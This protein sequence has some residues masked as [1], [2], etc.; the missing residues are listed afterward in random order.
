MLLILSLLLPGVHVQAQD[1]PA[2]TP[3][4]TG[5]FR[6][7]TCPFVLPAPERE[8][9]SYECGYVSV[10]M[11]YERNEGEIDLAV[12]IL[13]ATGS[14]VESDPILWLEGGP[15][16][17]ALV[18][19]DTNRK[20]VAQARE[21][22]DVILYDQRGAG[23]SG[24]LEC[25]S[26]QSQA[27]QSLAA[28]GTP[29]PSPLGSD[30]TIDEIYDYALNSA[31][32]GYPECWNG[33]ANAGIDP[34][35]FNTE[36][37]ARDSVEV[38]TALGYDQATLWGTSYGGRVAMAIMRDYPKWVR[39]AVLDSPLPIGIRRLEQF[40][41]LETEP[42][43]H[44]FA[45]C[46]ADAAC[47]R[48]YPDLEA[49]TLDLIDALK[50]SPIAVSSD[51]GAQAGLRG[52]FD[53]NA[54]VRL[55]T[56]SLPN[57]PLIAGAI[58]RAISDLENGDATV[59]LALLSGTYPPPVE[60][61][62][63]PSLTDTSFDTL[64]TPT[65]ARLALSLAMRTFVLCNDEAGAVTLD[66]IADSEAN[67]PLSMLRTQT[68]YR[69]AVTLFAQCRALDIEH[70]PLATDPP[71]APIPTLVLSGDYDA[72]TAPSW[73][74]AAADA[75]PS[76][77]L[78]SVPSAGHATARW[79]TCARDIASAFVDNPTAQLDTGC[80]SGEEPALLGPN[81]PLA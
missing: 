80:L 52:G 70:E 46:A 43:A 73:A 75:L 17:S 48:A 66:D 11:S 74:K 39:A 72:T 1:K 18:V 37:I 65:D 51:Q 19:A 10:P 45:W 33:Y 29:Y 44:L 6:S 81:D 49:R 50:R 35:Q 42:A 3:I 53:G 56:S 78:V 9:L 41:E 23:Y 12:A 47:N 68:P 55:L 63:P 4:A 61:D 14:A 71:T 20:I 38:L 76:A 5:T 79:S 58:P 40:A 2:A 67:A 15:G 7:A 16:A 25:G 30:A 59:A 64:R 28:A 34:A 57:N 77:T 24:Y 22:R 21:H 8:G 60:R 36:T 69:S 26:Y 32:L 27:A 13:R 31:A 62:I 54:L